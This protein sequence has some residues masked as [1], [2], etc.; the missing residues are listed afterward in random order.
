M[1]FP[2]EDMPVRQFMDD[3][4]IEWRTGARPQYVQVR[5]VYRTLP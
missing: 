5:H 4:D 3:P 1:E 2:E